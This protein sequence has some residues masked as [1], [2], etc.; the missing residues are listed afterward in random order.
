MTSILPHAKCIVLFVG[1]DDRRPKEQDSSEH[2]LRE[3]GAKLSIPVEVLNSKWISK[4]GLDL[5]FNTLKTLASPDNRTCLLIA[6]AY[7]E[8]QITVCTL[9]AL[10][11]G[12]DAHLLT[13][14]I[15]TRDERFTQTLLFRLL[16]AGAVPSTLNQFLYLWSAAEPC[17]YQQTAIKEVIQK[18][19]S[20]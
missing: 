4:L 15:I 3:I 10:A 9:E 17:E 5:L 20:N 12:F 8:D 16:Q 6:G 19:F 11:E 14:L 13:D 18:H 1:N 7:L 2:L